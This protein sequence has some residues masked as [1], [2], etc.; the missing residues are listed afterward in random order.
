MTKT[1]CQHDE[2]YLRIDHRSEQLGRPSTPAEVIETTLN[3]FFKDHK[4]RPLQ[5]TQI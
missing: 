3:I 4:I 2:N 1:A 5:K